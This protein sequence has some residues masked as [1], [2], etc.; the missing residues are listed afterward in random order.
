MDT[1]AGSHR[2]DASDIGDADL[3]EGKG[4]GGR[5]RENVEAAKTGHI[6]EDPG[7]LAA[8]VETAADGGAESDAGIDERGGQRADGEGG[9]DVEAFFTGGEGD[10]KGLVAGLGDIAGQGSGG[11]DDAFDGDPVG[12]PRAGREAVEADERRGREGRVAEA[13]QV[14]I[15][16]N[17]GV[18]ARRGIPLDA[19]EVAGAE[20]GRLIRGEPGKDATAGIEKK[21]SSAGTVESDDLSAA[22]KDREAAVG[23]G[24]GEGVDLARRAEGRE[25]GGRRGA[26]GRQEKEQQ[27]EAGGAAEG[28]GLARGRSC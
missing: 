21:E 13:L 4:V 1:V 17:G 8:L 10:L 15:D 22:E 16:D 25:W 5:G 12:I 3:G 11:A 7:E 20:N 23:R 27:E 24:A 28:K 14:G 26:G 9:P 19:D 18:A 2:A 6:E